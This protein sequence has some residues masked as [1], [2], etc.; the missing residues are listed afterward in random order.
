MIPRSPLTNLHFATFSPISRCRHC[1]GIEFT[2]FQPRSHQSSKSTSFHSNQHWANLFT[3]IPVIFIQSPHYSP[4]SIDFH[5]YYF[6]W[7]VQLIVTQLH[8]IHTILWLFSLSFI[9]H[10]SSSLHGELN[11]WISFAVSEIT[12]LVMDLNECLS[13]SA[14]TVWFWWLPSE[15]TLHCQSNNMNPFSYLYSSMLFGMGLEEHFMDWR[16]WKVI[17]IPLLFCHSSFIIHRYF[18]YLFYPNPQVC[19]SP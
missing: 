5:L 2:P 3:S 4:I 19:D 10:H 12:E 13:S 17:V 6:T 16:L 11:R 18:V 9:P 8:H 14:C 15:K 7:A 1:C